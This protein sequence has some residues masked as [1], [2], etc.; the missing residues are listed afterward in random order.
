MPSVIVLSSAWLMG[1]MKAGL[2]DKIQA[3]GNILG[4]FWEGT[5]HPGVVWRGEEQLEKPRTAM[6]KWLQQKED[7]RWASGAVASVVL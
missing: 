3:C 6:D 1:Q 4:A 5:E 7:A 2:K